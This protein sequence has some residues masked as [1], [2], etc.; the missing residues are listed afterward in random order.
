M[1]FNLTTDDVWDERER[2]GLNKPSN[3]TTIW[4]V[5]N[6]NNEVLFTGTISQIKGKVQKHFGKT[7][8]FSK[9]G[10]WRILLNDNNYVLSKL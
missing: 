6:T 5:K 2:L 8:R 4:E 9:K 7:A 1:G 3:T 10:R